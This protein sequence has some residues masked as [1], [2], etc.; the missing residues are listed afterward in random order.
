MRYVA[1]RNIS[2]LDAYLAR[3]IHPTVRQMLRVWS[4]G[5]VQMVYCVTKDVERF[6]T[7]SDTRSNPAQLL[8]PKLPVGERV[9]PAKVLAS[10]VVDADRDPGARDGM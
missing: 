9:D 2:M 1:H 10:E 5:G 4:M 7:I 8:R 6:G 3:P